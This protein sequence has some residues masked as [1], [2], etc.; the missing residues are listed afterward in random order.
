VEILNSPPSNNGGNLSD[1]TM[2]AISA[3]LVS[4]INVYTLLVLVP[5]K[6]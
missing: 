4:E 6:Y 1:D 3:D 5:N 2:D